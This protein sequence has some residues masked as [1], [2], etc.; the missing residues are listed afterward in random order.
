[1]KLL[2]LSVVL[3]HSN[4]PATR[5]SYFKLKINGDPRQNTEVKINAKMIRMLA[6]AVFVLKRLELPYNS[7]E[8]SPVVQE[9]SSIIT[10]LRKNYGSLSTISFSEGAEKARFGPE[11][12]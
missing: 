8:D 4:A 7:G 6:S 10:M 2:V 9:I 1:M 11:H 3:L 5:L 12:F